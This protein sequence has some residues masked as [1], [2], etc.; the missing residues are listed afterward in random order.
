MIRP[1]RVAGVEFSVTDL[2]RVHAFASGA[3]P[4]VDGIH[5]IDLSFAGADLQE[6]L[7]WLVQDVAPVLRLEVRTR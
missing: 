2:N 6:L 5:D 1:L 3:D 4:D 7:D